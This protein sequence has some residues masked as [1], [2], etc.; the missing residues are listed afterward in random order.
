MKPELVAGIQSSQGSTKVAGGFI[1]LASIVDSLGSIF[2]MYVEVARYASCSLPE[3]DHGLLSTSFKL[4]A[5]KKEALDLLETAHS[6][7]VSEADG[8]GD[9][10]RNTVG[11]VLTP[12][13]VSIALMERLVSGMFQRGSVDVVKVYEACLEQLVS[14]AFLAAHSV[15][16]TYFAD[17]E[18]QT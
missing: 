17:L 14:D 15:N 16:L 13:A 12:E 2:C 4:D 11:P 8:S 6:Q 18:S 7:L 10:S 1:L 9:D 3:R 5:Y